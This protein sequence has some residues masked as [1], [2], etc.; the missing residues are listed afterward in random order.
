M[1]SHDDRL[2]LGQTTPKT[3]M[4]ALIRQYWQPI[5][6]ASDLT[7]ADPVR[8]VRVLSEDVVLF[9][10]KSGRL[11]CL[12]ALCPHAQGELKRGYVEPE[13]LVCGVHGWLF[14][15]EGNSKVNWFFPSQA[16]DGDR[17]PAYPVLERAGL[18]WV[19]LGPGPAP[20]S[21]GF[22]TLNQPTGRLRIT[23]YPVQSGH[24]LIEHTNGLW[25]WRWHVRDGGRLP[26]ADTT[27]F[28]VEDGRIVREFDGAALVLPSHLETSEYLWLRTPVDQSNTWQVKIEVIHDSDPAEPPEII[29]LDPRDT[30]HPPDHPTR[31]YSFYS[32]WAEP[33]REPL[34]TE[35]DPDPTPSDD[36][37][38]GLELFRHEIY[39]RL[40]ALKA[41][42]P[43]GT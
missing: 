11:G 17:Y 35:D 8:E 26:T 30:P 31:R 19:Y 32:A 28:F 3:E 40:D 1:F 39:A 14:D 18:L 12:P 27:S 23:R 22:L 7:D 33:I 20:S 24:W 29:H 41:A 10:D 2:L 15:T 37:P 9:R 21:P 4:G 43:A 34:L 42:Q 36:L 5:A 16:V 6:L 38:P 13:G 25:A